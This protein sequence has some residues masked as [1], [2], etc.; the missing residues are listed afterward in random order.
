MYSFENGLRPASAGSCN[1]AENT[2]AS[3]CRRFSF[4]VAV[5][6]QSTMG[7]RLQLLLSSL[8]PRAHSVAHRALSPHDMGDLSDQGSN[9]SLL[10]HAMISNGTTRKTP[11]PPKS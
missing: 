1:K 10:L 8:D 2:P 4:A 7:S 9:P 6:G 5:T 3:A 11:P